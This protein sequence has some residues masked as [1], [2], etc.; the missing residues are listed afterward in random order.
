MSTMVDARA[1]RSRD[2]I[3]TALAEVAA[4]KG[5]AGFSV[6]EVADR[7]GVSHRTVYRHY[8]TREAL[9]DGYARW[10]DL[11]LRDRGSVTEPETA[12]TIPA[13]AAEVFERFDDIPDLI[14]T[15]VKVSLGTGTRVP[16]RDERTEEF[17]EVMTGDGLTDH[18]SADDAELVVALVRTLASSNTWFVFRHER[19][20]GGER[21]GRAVAWALDTLLSELRHGGGPGT[22][23]NR[24]G[25]R[26]TGDD[27]DDR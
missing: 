9:L 21:A 13:A 2:R 5:V 20:I 3:M 22:E 27:G 8:E 26:H 11:R 4:E 14:D 16:R 6:Q 17:R 24:D 10:L 18:L 15:F 12:A 7:A 19:G 1:Q 23:A 25:K